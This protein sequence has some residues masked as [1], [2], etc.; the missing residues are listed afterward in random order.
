[1]LTL[2]SIPTLSRL[3]GFEDTADRIQYRVYATA[4]QGRNRTPVTR[5]F[6]IESFESLARDEVE[7][8]AVN[9]FEQLTREGGSPGLA[10]RG[11]SL[12]EPFCGN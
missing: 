12:S 2:G 7:R 11:G 1:M 5:Y 6:T 3:T 10:G 9:A 8:L 4:Y